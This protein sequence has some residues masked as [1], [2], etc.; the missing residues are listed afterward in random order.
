VAAAPFRVTDEEED[1]V[2]CDR[3][4]VE[5]RWGDGSGSRVDDR[6]TVSRAMFC[7]YPACRQDYGY[8]MTLFIIF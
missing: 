1:D 5:W 2:G 4:E 6:G 3:T 8:P 7:C